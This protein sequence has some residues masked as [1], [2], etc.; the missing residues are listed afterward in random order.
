MITGGSFALVT[1][2][3]WWGRFSGKNIPVKGVNAEKILKLVG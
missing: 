1:K 2:Q 3:P